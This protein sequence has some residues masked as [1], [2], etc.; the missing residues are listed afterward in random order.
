[1]K[2][3]LI[4]DELL[5]SKSISILIKKKG[6]HITVTGNG[7]TALEL[8]KNTK[9]DLIITDLML[10]DISGF[11]IIDEC[12]SKYN[13][14]AENITVITAYNSNDIINKIKQYKCKYFIKPFDNLVKTIDDIINEN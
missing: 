2:I 10:N 13:Y 14:T 9:F 5:I 3:L 4:E 8:L 6:H 11:D 7:V 12:L 1:M